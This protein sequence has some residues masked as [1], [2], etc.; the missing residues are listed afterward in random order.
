MMRFGRR[1][2][3]PEEQQA[4]RRHAARLCWISIVMLTTTAIAVYLTLGQS[5][6]M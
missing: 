4:Q 2:R 3:F 1:F 6:A 5:E